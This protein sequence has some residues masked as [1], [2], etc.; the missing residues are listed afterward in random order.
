MLMLF[1][2]FSISTSR[3]S[4]ATARLGLQAK[5]AGW[6]CVEELQGGSGEEKSQLLSLQF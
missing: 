2:G 5:C 3:Y 1:L 4:S 6:R